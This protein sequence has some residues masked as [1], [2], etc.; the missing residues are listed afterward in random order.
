M[1]MRMPVVCVAV[2]VIA[3]AIGRRRIGCRTII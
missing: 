1:I 2:R 3:I